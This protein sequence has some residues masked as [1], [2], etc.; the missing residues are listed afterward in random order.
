MEKIEFLNGR[1]GNTPVTADKLNKLQGNIENEFASVTERNHAGFKLIAHR[2][3]MSEAPE[4]TLK[5]FEIAKTQGFWGTEMDVQKTSDGKYICF[6][7]GTVDR[8]TNGTGNVADMTLEQIQALTI[9]AGSNVDTFTGLK[10]PTFEEFLDFCYKID[11]VP[12]IELKEETLTEADMEPILNLIKNYGLERKCVI[13]SFIKD[14]LIKMRELSDVISIQY[15]ITTLTETEI[16]GCA[17]YNFDVD[18]RYSSLTLDLVK[19]AHSKG[20]K[21]NVW[22]I[23]SVTKYNTVKITYPDFIST[24]SILYQA[25]FESP[26][27]TNHLG[28]R[29]YSEFQKKAVMYPSDFNGTMLNVVHR[30]LGTSQINVNNV[31][32]NTDGTD[33]ASVYA[34]APDRLVCLNK[35]TINE[36]SKL[37]VEIPTGYRIG[38]RCFDSNDNQL[39]DMGW[40]TSAATY[41]SG[42]PT[43]TK[44][45]YIYASKEDDSLITEVDIQKI[46]KAV[47]MNKETVLF[48]GETTASFNLLDNKNRYEMVRVEFYGLTNEDTK[49]PSSM[50]IR[51]ESGTQNVNLM[52]SW[53]NTDSSIWIETLGIYLKD[54][55]VTIGMKKTMTVATTGATTATGKITITKVIG[56]NNV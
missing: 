52:T 13:I 5:A 48:S 20:L 34:S 29:A 45:G 21:V 30:R 53:W 47:K 40:S 23:D 56:I 39:P 38:I 28:I 50:T 10:V 7:D 44:Y 26:V 25:D 22:T 8:M 36:N 16:D 43:G 18:T 15:I 6:H 17:E 37:P 9:D 35:L 41:I 14:L 4:N 51:V 42:F 55:N 1:S 2:G 24:N 32:N 3:A 19:Y 11:I 46:S 12:V 54:T 31:L 27:Y 49:I 33:Y